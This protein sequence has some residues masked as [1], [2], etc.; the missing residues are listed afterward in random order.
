MCQDDM[1]KHLKKISDEDYK[2]L[3]D[4]AKRASEGMN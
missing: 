3:N 4:E 2:D 1:D